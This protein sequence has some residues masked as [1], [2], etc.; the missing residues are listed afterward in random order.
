VF[1]QQHAIT[2]WRN[3]VEFEMRQENKT[4]KYNTKM[5]TMKRSA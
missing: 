2:L 5:M 4:L 1:L 3:V